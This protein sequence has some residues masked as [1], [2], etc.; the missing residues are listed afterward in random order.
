MPCNS[1]ASEQGGGLW[2]GRARLRTVLGNAP[3]RRRA[4]RGARRQSRPRYEQPRRTARCHRSIRWR[5]DHFRRRR[6]AVTGDGFRRWDRGC[7]LAGSSTLNRLELGTAEASSD[8]YKRIAADAEA[9]YRRTGEPARRYRDFR[10][11]TRKSWSRSRRVVGKAQY[12]AKGPNP[13]FAVTNL[14]AERADAKH[15]YEALYCARDDMENRIKEQ[16]LGLFAD[17]TSSC[18]ATIRVRRRVASFKNAPRAI[19]LGSISDEA[20]RTSRTLSRTPLTAIRSGSPTCGRTAGWCWWNSGPPGAV[21]A[22]PR[23]RT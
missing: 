18:G 17:R 15:L 7:P 16:Q 11:R 19:V 9:E 8:R 4:Q 21:P 5:S 12:L 1:M 22:G 3:G 13:R 6:G 20:M 10:Y 14:S 2:R 23:F